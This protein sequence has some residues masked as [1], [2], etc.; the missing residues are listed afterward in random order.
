M[1]PPQI[2]DIITRNLPRLTNVAVE[3]DAELNALGADCLTRL[4][5]AM[6]ISEATGRDVPD[7]EVERWETVADVAR[8]LEKAAA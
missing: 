1:T 3:P 7:C 6:D 8:A 5:I 2:A 4:G